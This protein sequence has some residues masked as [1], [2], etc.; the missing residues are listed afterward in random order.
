[1]T[2]DY[3]RIAALHGESYFLPLEHIST[4]VI[5]G[6]IIVTASLTLLY[7]V[8][9]RLPASRSHDVKQQRK[10]AYQF[11][12]LCVNTVLGGLGLFYFLNLQPDPTVE[13]QIIGHNELYPICK[14]A[15]G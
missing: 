8:H 5:P 4:C 3:D 9:L 14:Q 12:N 7:N 11:T 10:A 2:T 15:I 1:M 6:L 13:E